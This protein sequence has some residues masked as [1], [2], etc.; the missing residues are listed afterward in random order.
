ML[1][2]LIHIHKSTLNVIQAITERLVATCI[3]KLSLVHWYLSKSWICSSKLQ[4]FPSKSTIYPGN[5]I[6]TFPYMGADLCGIPCNS[7]Y[8]NSL[9]WQTFP[10]YP[11]AQ[12]HWN[13]STWSS[14]R[15]PFWQGRVEHSLISDN[16]TKFHERISENYMMLRKLLKIISSSKKVACKIQHNR[17]YRKQRRK[18][19]KKNQHC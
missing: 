2:H 6:S 18:A 7:I 19:K 4:R 8:N 16:C 13:P 11:L 14:Q 9:N 12:R 1:F 5:E 10:S 15:P 3:F 17:G